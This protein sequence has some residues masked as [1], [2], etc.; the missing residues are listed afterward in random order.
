MKEYQNEGTI[1]RFARLFV[2]A[3]LLL[4]AYFW[5]GGV[6]Q[7]V[8]YVLAAIS[9]FTA[10]TGF[11]L[12]YKVLR[13]SGTKESKPLPTSV[14][15]VLV[16]LLMVLLIVGSY[17]SAFF[18]KKFFLDDYNQMNNY[19][20]QT[21]FFTGQDKR[22]EA[23]ENYDNLV[24]K[25]ED[26]LTKY[27][28]YRPY[29]LRN[30]SYF[31]TDIQAVSDKINSLH[32]AVYS[33]NLYEAHLAFETIRPVFQDILKRN[34]FSMLAVVLVDFHDSMEKI[35][36]AA[37]AKDVAQVKS[38]YVEVDTKLKEVEAIANDAE[39]QAIRTNLDTVLILAEQEQSDLLP[40]KAAELKSSFVKVYLKRG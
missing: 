40:A 22:T 37:D 19:Y 17:Y 28:A 11:C 4:G 14:S 13:L 7:I 25:Y 26:F 10:L 39:I 33:G 5:V 36:D 20:K 12:L 16:V 32:D 15:I 38:T 6:W 23:I 34:N 35:I 27:S 30:D 8:L 29:A 18:T 31:A 2:A 1:D 3:F 21:L 9:L 24:L